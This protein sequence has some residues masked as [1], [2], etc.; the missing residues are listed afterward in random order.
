MPP[1]MGS[2]GK[3]VRV[4][5]RAHARGA[6]D[7]GE[8]LRDLATHTAPPVPDIAATPLEQELRRAGA[9]PAH[10]DEAQAE[11]VLWQEFKT[12]TLRLTMR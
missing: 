4:S 9:P 11:K 2:M 10:F 3:P 7:A 8:R 5:P 6:G 12:T 1:W